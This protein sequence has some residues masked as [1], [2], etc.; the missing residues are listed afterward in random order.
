MLGVGGEHTGVTEGRF[1]P[2]QR[3]SPLAKI[4]IGIRIVGGRKHPRQ[5]NLLPD[6]VCLSTYWFDDY[7]G[8]LGFIDGAFG[9]AS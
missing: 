7:I 2:S 3:Q 8:T 6:V 9:K 5:L 4:A 1:N